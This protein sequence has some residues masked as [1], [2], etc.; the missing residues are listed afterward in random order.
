MFIVLKFNQLNSL[1]TAHETKWVHL[2]C[3]SVFTVYFFW[4]LSDLFKKNALSLN[5]SWICPEFKSVHVYLNFVLFI[6]YEVHS[7]LKQIEYLYW[8]I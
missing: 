5:T 1:Q 2:N 8:K 7:S 4:K 6:F 3:S